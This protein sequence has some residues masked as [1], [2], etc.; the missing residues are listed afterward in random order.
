M[1]APQVPEQMDPELMAECDIERLAV[2]WIAEHA[3]ALRAFA[4]EEEAVWIEDS[5]G[6]IRCYPPKRRLLPDGHNIV[7]WCPLTAWSGEDDLICTESDDWMAQRAAESGE[8]IAALRAIVAAADREPE[9]SEDVRDAL[10]RA[11]RCGPFAP[12]TPPTGL[13]WPTVDGCGP[14]RPEESP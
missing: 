10:M 3:P 8:N 14:P 6:S 5:I 11:L 2:Q 13:D 1:S 9:F 12:E 7:R 4:A